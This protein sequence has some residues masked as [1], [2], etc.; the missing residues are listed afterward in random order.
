[1]SDQQTK[2][3][4][5][6]VSATVQLYTLL[7]CD[8][9]VLLQGKLKRSNFAWLCKQVTTFS[10]LTVREYNPSPVIVPLNDTVGLSRNVKKVEYIPLT[11]M[12][13]GIEIGVCIATKFGLRDSKIENR[14][15]YNL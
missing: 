2:R 15:Q 9:D 11:C 14:N 6:S 10:S 12:I 3:W 8:T 13:I 4:A 1:M 5:S 7:R